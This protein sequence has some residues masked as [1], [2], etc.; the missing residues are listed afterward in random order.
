ML[1][2]RNVVVSWRVLQGEEKKTIIH[3]YH[4]AAD[5]QT[6]D[7][8]KEV[9]SI[10]HYVSSLHNIE[11]NHPSNCP[12][13]DLNLYNLGCADLVLGWGANKV[14]VW[15]LEY[16]YVTATV[17]ILESVPLNSPLSVKCDRVTDFPQEKPTVNNLCSPQGFLFLL[18]QMQ[19][20]NLCLI[21]INNGMKQSWKRL[22]TFVAPKQF[23]KYVSLTRSPQ[24]T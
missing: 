13:M 10:D 9:Q 20:G 8:I 12:K 23:E 5:Y 3:C 15:N 4:L 16:G 24:S 18:Q 1:N 7:V 6:V 22:Q 17:E 14:T 11:G 2:S 19:N 21:A